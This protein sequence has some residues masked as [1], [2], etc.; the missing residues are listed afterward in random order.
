M[1]ETKTIPSWLTEKL[2]TENVDK[3]IYCTEC[4]NA[5]LPGEIFYVNPY[6]CEWCEECA[7]KEKE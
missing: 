4:Y 7:K 2:H 5:I 1:N 3:Q 6:G